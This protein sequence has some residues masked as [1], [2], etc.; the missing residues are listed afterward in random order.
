MAGDLLPD[1][2]VA[3]MT[4]NQVNATLIGLNFEPLDFDFYD[5]E[6]GYAIRADNNYFIVPG[7]SQGKPFFKSKRFHMCKPVLS[8]DVLECPDD[9]WTGKEL[10][11]IIL[12]TD[13]HVHR[14]AIVYLAQELWKACKVGDHPQIVAD[15]AVARGWL[16]DF[17]YGKM[18]ESYKELFV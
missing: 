13:P 12:K 17:R 3:S 6:C 7:I 15:R 5:G 14:D 11:E 10:A 2:N 1:F 4:I 8:T 18:P 9:F 16:E